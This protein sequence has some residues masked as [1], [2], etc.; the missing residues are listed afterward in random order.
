MVSYILRRLLASIPLLI[1]ISIVSFII[2]QLPPGD[3][4]TSYEMQLINRPICRPKMLRRQPTV[5]TRCMGS[6]S[7]FG[8]S[9]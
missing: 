8:N 7:R 4:A 2:I 1:G 5:T 6:T 3:F 9:I